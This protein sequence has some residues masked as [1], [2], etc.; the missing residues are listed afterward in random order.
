MCEYVYTYPPTK[1]INKATFH[2]C[3]SKKNVRDALMKIKGITPETRS[4]FRNLK[5]EEE[6][7]D[8]N[9][10]QWTTGLKKDLPEF[11]TSFNQRFSK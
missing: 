10:D 6:V 8:P 1:N 11:W 9:F 3:F 5:R 4:F 7:D 2:F